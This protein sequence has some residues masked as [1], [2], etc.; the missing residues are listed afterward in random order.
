FSLPVLFKQQEIP[1]GEI[2]IKVTGN[3]WYWSYEYVDDGF[4]FDSFLV[5]A[6]YK[7]NDPENGW[8]DDQ[9]MGPPQVRSDVAVQKLEY[10]GYSPDEFLLATDTAVV[11]PV[12]KIVVMHLTG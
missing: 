9:P 3:Q 4:A 12:G 5:D 6:S 11:V 7:I 8:G 10:F 1:D 2:N